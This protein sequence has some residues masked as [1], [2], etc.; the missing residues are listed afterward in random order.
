MKRPDAMTREELQDEVVYLRGELGL[1]RDDDQIANLRRAYPMHRGAARLVMALRA[2]GQRGLTYQ[3]LD[4]AIPQVH[5]SGGDRGIK[6]IS[7]WASY[8]RKA[9]GPGVIETI[10]GK[11]LRLSPNGIALVD[12]ALGNT[13]PSNRGA[14][15]D[16]DHDRR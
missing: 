7:V 5:D 4:E 3:Q 14:R 13:P 2:A 16:E 10:W 15:D 1:L 12:A 6:I 9:L 11:G 8:A